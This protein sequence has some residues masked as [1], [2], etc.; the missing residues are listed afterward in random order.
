MM[1]RNNT[2]IEGH[3]RAIITPVS[4]GTNRSHGEM[5]KVFSKPSINSATL[6][7]PDTFMVKPATRKMESDIRKVGTVV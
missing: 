1:A 3:R 2:T 4:T 7:L 5:T 6:P